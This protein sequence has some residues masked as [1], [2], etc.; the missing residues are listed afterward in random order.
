MKNQSTLERIE[1]LEAEVKELK[2]SIIAEEK[3]K[4]K[5]GDIITHTDSQ[6]KWI[7]VFKGYGINEF[8]TYGFCYNPSGEI[9]CGNFLKWASDDNSELSTPEEKQTL[10]DAMHKEGKDF[11]FEKLEV[12]DWRWRAK[13]GG[14][15]VAVD[16]EGIVRYFTDHRSGFSTFKHSIGNYF[17]PTEEGERQAE[18]YKRFYYKTLTDQINKH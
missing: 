10:L 18:E 6:G 17:P 4:F 16:T 5:A 14:S 13:D 9:Q 7:A 11:D 3:P 12:I 1:K 8:R 2:L 15:Y